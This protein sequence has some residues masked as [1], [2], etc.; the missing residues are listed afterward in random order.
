MVRRRQV[1][2]EKLMTKK[3]IQREAQSAQALREEERAIVYQNQPQSRNHQSQPM[4]GTMPA[5]PRM[6]TLK[7]TCSGYV[8][9]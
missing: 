3:L 9:L 7:R 4:I 8:E 5:K 1:S 2:I 6:P